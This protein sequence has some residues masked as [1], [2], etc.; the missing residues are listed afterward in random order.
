L[1]TPSLS[2]AVRKSLETDRNKEVMKQ[3]TGNRKL[4]TGNWKLE[5]GQAT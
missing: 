1:N 2:S 3:E 5:T 4:E